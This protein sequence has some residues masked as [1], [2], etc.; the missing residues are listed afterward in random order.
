MVTFE[1][2]SSTEMGLGAVDVATTILSGT[3]GPK[4][5]G[6]FKLPP[7]PRNGPIAAVQGGHERLGGSLRYV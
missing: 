7:W 4:G 3:S 6:G 5:G 1:H 2:C